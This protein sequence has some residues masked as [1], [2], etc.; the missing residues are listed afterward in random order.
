MRCIALLNENT[1]RADAQFIGVFTWLQDGHVKT[2]VAHGD[3]RQAGNSRA[4]RKL[5]QA[6]KP[7]GKD[8][9]KRVQP[10]MGVT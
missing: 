7:R 1:R 5:P 3:S 2:G 10:V 6:S 9:T 8:S 4:R